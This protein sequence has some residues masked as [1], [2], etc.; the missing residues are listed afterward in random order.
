MVATVTSTLSLLSLSSLSFC[1]IHTHKYTEIDSKQ[2]TNPCRI[3]SIIGWAAREGRHSQV[4]IIIL[5]ETCG[6]RNNKCGGKFRWPEVRSMV[7]RYLVVCSVSS[8]LLRLLLRIQF[9]YLFFLPVFI[10]SIFFLY[11]YS[12]SSAVLP[13]F[14][15]VHFRFF[16]FSISLFA[17]TFMQLCHIFHFHVFSFCH[18]LVCMATYVEILSVC[19]IP[20][21][22][23]S[24]NYLFFTV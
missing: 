9:I 13:L 4:S 14:S 3:L 17:S 20:S 16:P 12:F 15:F 10:I 7:S 18:S 19:N 1:Y 22:F 6:P 21:C 23:F 11:F 24:F 5:V 2:N 8:S